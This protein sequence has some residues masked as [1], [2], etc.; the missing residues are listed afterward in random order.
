MGRRWWVCNPPT[1]ERDHSTLCAE[2]VEPNI[3][4]ALADERPV[5]P[6]GGLLENLQDG[7]RDILRVILSE[8][9]LTRLNKPMTARE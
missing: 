8:E 4:V 1:A 5:S 7:Q 3:L 9:G 2:T 6:L